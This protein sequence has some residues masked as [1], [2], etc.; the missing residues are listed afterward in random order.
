MNKKFSLKKHC[1]IL[2]TLDD[3]LRMIQQISI[4]LIGLNDYFLDIKNKCSYFLL[5]NQ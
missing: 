3:Y 2:S 4:N 1:R 5:R